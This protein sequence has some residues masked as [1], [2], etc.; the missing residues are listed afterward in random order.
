MIMMQFVH[1]MKPSKSV[2]HQECVM[3]VISIAMMISIVKLISIIVVKNTLGMEHMQNSVLQ[4]ISTP[5]LM[6]NFGSRLI[7]RILL[8]RML[9][10]NG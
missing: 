7:M 6:P 1:V 9:Y 5:I 10:L 8:E 2:K 3:H 4:N